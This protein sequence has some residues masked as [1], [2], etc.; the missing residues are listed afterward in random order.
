MK[1]GIQKLIKELEAGILNADINISECC[2]S[3]ADYTKG[4]WDGQK[5]ALRICIDKLTLLLKPGK[6]NSSKSFPK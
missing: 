5:K 1:N 3:K 6:K 2:K 4:Q